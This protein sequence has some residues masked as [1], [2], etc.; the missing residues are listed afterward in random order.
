MIT[1][2]YKETF[3]EFNEQAP[4]LLKKLGYTDEEINNCINE[5]EKENKIRDKIIDKLKEKYHISKY[6]E[7]FPVMVY[8]IN[9]DDG[10]KVFIRHDCSKGIDVYKNDR[11]DYTYFDP[12]EDNCLEKITEHIDGLINNI[13]I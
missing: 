2:N 10:D 4:T 12:L 3:K 7:D 11:F 6:R 1:I 13:K 9:L 8:S 5:V